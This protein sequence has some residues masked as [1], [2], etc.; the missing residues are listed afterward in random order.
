[1]LS[2][3]AIKYL[4]TLG[5]TAN[6]L[7]VVH[8][9]HHAVSF[10]VESGLL[11]HPQLEDPGLTGAQ[12]AASAQVQEGALTAVLDVMVHFGVLQRREDRYVLGGE[13]RLL[14]QS[15]HNQAYY[16]MR[17][18]ACVP[19]ASLELAQTL[20]TG[21][22]GIELAYG[23]RL[24]ERASRDAAT[25]AAVAGLCESFSASCDL[26]AAAVERIARGGHRTIVDL[27]GGHGRLLT[28][29]L[30]KSPASQGV[31]LDLP[32]VIARYRERL[33][34]VSRL[35]LRGGDFFESV[36]RADAYILCNVLAN[37]NQEA[38]RKLLHA[39]HG[40]GEPGGT[41]YILDLFSDGSFESALLNL[42]E[43]V[44]TGGAYHRLDTLEAL[45]QS[46]GLS[47]KERIDGD[48]AFKLLVCG[49]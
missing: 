28:S 40:A 48:S 12:L 17:V 21:R 38:V 2:K 36:P 3:E 7:S 29:I 5:G 41:L 22:S 27:G 14:R 8:H 10:L 39:V 45:V 46:S 13:G 25:S 31:L 18:A 30:E 34:G 15:E 9:L 43:L 20:R 23:E 33:A 19:R 49:L 11:E 44:T 37:W 6:F 47:V 42:E 16:A 32:A 1:M 35:T 26:I 4:E 24:Y